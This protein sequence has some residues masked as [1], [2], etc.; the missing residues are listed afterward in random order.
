[1]TQE[2]LKE[3]FDYHPDG[4]FVEKTKRSPRVYIG[5]ITKG[6]K[7]SIKEPYLRLR[8]DKK[9]YLLHRMVFLWHHGYLP[10]VVDH[11]DFNLANNR[12]SNLRAATFADSARY[13]RA[14]IKSKTGYKG[15]YI[16]KSGGFYSV[17]KL[18][19]K[20]IRLGRFDK[21]QDAAL[22]YNIKAKELFGDFAYLNNIKE[23]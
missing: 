2:R 16:A 19:K 9:Q 14:G 6:Q 18:N 15:V 11:I 4:F 7:N 10:N 21:I 22:A 20:T 8:I 12:I 3:L 23:K 1:M 13:V 5:K 17:I